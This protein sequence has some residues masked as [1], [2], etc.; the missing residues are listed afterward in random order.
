M[1][2][3]AGLERLLRSDLVTPDMHRIHHTRDSR[4]GQSNFGGTFP[5]WDRLLGSYLDTP[6]AGQECLAFGVSGFGD[7][8]HLSLSWMLAQPF[9]KEGA[10]AIEPPENRNVGVP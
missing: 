10:D 9:L 1:R 7:R 5:W 4:E 8:K 3:P 6:S 2:T